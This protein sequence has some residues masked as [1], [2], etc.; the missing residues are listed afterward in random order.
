MLWILLCLA[1]I[2]VGWINAAKAASKES[3]IFRFPASLADGYFPDGRLTQDAAGN[4]YGTT[5]LGTTATNYNG[6]VFKFAPPVGSQTTGQ[7]TVL[8]QFTGATGAQ[9]QGSLALGAKGTLFGTTPLGGNGVN[10]GTLF[11]LLPPAAGQSKWTEVLIRAFDNGVD[12]KSP[13]AGLLVGK[14]GTLYG[15][16]AADTAGY[17]AIFAFTPPVTAKATWTEKI[18]YNFKGGADGFAPSGS[19]ISDATGT[20]YGTTLDSGPTVPFG[21]GN[22][23][24]FEMIPPATG[25]TAWTKQTL[26][27][28]TGAADGSLPLAPLLRD[29]GGALY[30]VTKGGNGTV[31]KL[32]PP[33]TGKPSWVLTTLYTFRG[34]ADG[35]TPN[36]GLVMDTTGA[37]IGTTFAGGSTKGYGT[38]FKLTPPKTAAGK[39]TETV[40]HAFSST[41]D[42]SSAASI[43]VSPGGT[44]FGITGYG[45][46]SGCKIFPYPGGCGTIFKLTE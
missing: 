27:S 6:T 43:L 18:L 25:K 42:G 40:L 31:F 41:P 45:G 15:A 44:L 9:P 24:I 37:L 32:A 12:G 14:N 13:A 36:P 10:D 19:L 17:G 30:G 38:V 26:Y 21:A 1:T 34:G 22:G 4:L 28:F 20:L 35:Q 39:W 2:M 8:Y 46:N 16:L 7:L 29:K 5:A 3:V 23:T 33:S 11:E